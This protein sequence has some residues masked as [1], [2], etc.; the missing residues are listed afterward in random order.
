MVKDIKL[1]LDTIHHSPGSTIQGKLMVSVDKPKK[2]H[3]IIVTLWGA[4]TVSWQV[5][6][7]KHTIT[8]SNLKMYTHQQSLVWKALDSPTGKLPIGEHHFPFGFQL[9][10]DIPPSF[11]GQHGKVSYTVAAWIMETGGLIRSNRPKHAIETFLIVKDERPRPDIMRLYREPATV[12]KTKTLKFLFFKSGS[13]SATVTLPRTGFSPGE[14]IPISISVN[15]QSSRQIHVASIL[16]RVDA[17]TESRGTCMVKSNLIAETL[18]SPIM[19]GT[20]ASYEDRNLRVPSG[21][22]KTMR[23]C[24][25]ISVKYVV[26]VIIRIPWSFNKILKLPVVIANGDSTSLAGPA[27][28][29]FSTQHQ[30]AAGLTVPAPPRDPFLPT[31]NEA[32]RTLL[33]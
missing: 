9:P 22:Y 13:I 10:Q 28:S 6:R 19:P 5:N 33:S 3:S 25:C 2:Y 31:Y 32:V 4:A 1:F 11:K 8:L 26:I 7:D 20:N 17:F 12:D 23:S 29:P 21:A 15:N 16:Q 27:V 18:S 14:T 30:Q 24:S